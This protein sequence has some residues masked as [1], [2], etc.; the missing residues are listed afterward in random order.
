MSQL[1][2]IRN[3]RSTL[4]EAI[5]RL[6]K[7]LDT[8]H[9][10]TIVGEPYI[11]VEEG[12]QMRGLMSLNSGKFIIGPMS[13][14][15]IGVPHFAPDAAADAAAEVTG[16]Y[17]TKLVPMFARDW[18]RARLY[19]YRQSLAQLDELIANIEAGEVVA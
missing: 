9:G 10:A 11:L 3:A 12:L 5:D 6:E 16:K 4:L 8:S 17:G 7:R 2:F 19:E 1:E 13:D 18:Q 15:L 14:M